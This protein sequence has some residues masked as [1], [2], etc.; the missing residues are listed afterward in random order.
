MRHYNQYSLLI[1][2]FCFSFGAATAQKQKA[3][4]RFRFQSINQVGLLNGETGASPQLQTVNGV[5]YKSWFGGLGIGL[6]Y[7]QFRSIP[8]F[9]DFRKTFGDS[10]NKVFVYGDGGISC[11]WVTTKEK[12]N[13]NGTLDRFSNGWYVDG[14]LGYQIHISGK[15]ALLLSLGYSYKTVKESIP[16]YYPVLYMPAIDFTPG[17]PPGLATGQ[18]NRYD[19]HFNRISIKIGWAFR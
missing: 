19:Y 2:L 9:A 12:N 11:S 18:T 5:Q 7:Y 6:D 14:G 3:N 4:N 8:V 15:N 1:I 13:Y 16:V 17:V 10:K